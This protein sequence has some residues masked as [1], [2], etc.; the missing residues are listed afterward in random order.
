M[1]YLLDSNIIIDFLKGALNTNVY[2]FLLPIIDDEVILSIIS[3]MEILGF[4]FENENEENIYKTFIENSLILN[5]YENIVNKT[6]EIRKNKKIRLADAIIAST[7][8][9]NDYTLITR[10]I[11]DFKNINELKFLDYSEI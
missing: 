5:L 4:N 2:E 11:K 10:N 9:S 1:K 6:I 3:K 8:I 7:A